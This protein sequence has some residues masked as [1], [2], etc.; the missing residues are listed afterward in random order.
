[1]QGVA[2]SGLA[3]LKP[4]YFS[5]FLMRRP[6]LSY[7]EDSFGC[8]ELDLMGYDDIKMLKDHCIKKLKKQGY[9]MKGY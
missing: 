3:W 2:S 5:I 7:G 4:S 6:T 1:M 8:P 9:D